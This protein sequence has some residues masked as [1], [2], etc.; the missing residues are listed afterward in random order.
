[1]L[2]HA[3]GDDFEEGELVRERLDREEDLRA[4]HLVDLEVASALR[5]REAAGK[6][7]PD[8]AATALYVFSVLPINR[9]PHGG[10]LPRVWELRD[11]LRPY[12]AIYVALAEALGCALLT[13]DR[14]IARAPALM[15]SVEVLG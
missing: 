2:V 8:R 3:F 9:Y 7:T 14:R 4:P 5:R 10:F 12:D 15:C 11:N 1:M 6:I 13:R